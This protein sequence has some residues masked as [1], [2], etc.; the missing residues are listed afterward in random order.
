MEVLDALSSPAL[1]RY[2]LMAAWHWAAVSAAAGEA[3]ASVP[4]RAEVAT[5]TRT[6]WRR[7]DRSRS[8]A[9]P[10]RIGRNGRSG[11]GRRQ[12]N[13]RSGRA[14]LY[15]H[16]RPA[17]RRR[18]HQHRRDRR[19]GRGLAVGMVAGPAAPTHR[20]PQRWAAAGPGRPGRGRRPGRRAAGAG[21]RPAPAEHLP[22]PAAADGHHRAPARAHSIPARP[23]PRSRSGAT[24][25]RGPPG[26]GGGRDRAGPL[27]VGRGRRAGPRRR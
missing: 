17:P 16:R 1:A 25:R 14:F 11:K 24:W 13:R 23:G 8:A 3:T 18:G 27:R 15:A 26:T 5:T 6:S 19:G 21:R 7:V 2:W 4:S 10:G 12:G 9:L 20:D 22:E